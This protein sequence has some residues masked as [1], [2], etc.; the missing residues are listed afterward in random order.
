MA[1]FLRLRFGAL[2]SN[3]R[4]IY[5]LGA[6]VPAWID[7][8][9]RVT[10]ALTDGTGVAVAAYDGDGTVMDAPAMMPPAPAMSWMSAAR[11]RSR[12]AR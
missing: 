8:R 12:W 10:G 6:E 5:D 11:A 2:P 9:D 7:I 1:V 3:A 4:P